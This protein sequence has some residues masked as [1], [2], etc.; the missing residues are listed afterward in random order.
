MHS[1]DLSERNASGNR[2]RRLDPTSM[3]N[4]YFSHLDNPF[5]MINALLMII[6]DVL[7]NLLTYR[8]FSIALITL[9]ISP[10]P[11]YTSDI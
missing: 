4:Q 8:K 2:N 10:K 1:A 3:F 6:T 9:I 11:L 7:Y 5:L